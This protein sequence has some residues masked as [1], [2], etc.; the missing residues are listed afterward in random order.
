MMIAVL[1]MTA[2]L[3]GHMVSQSPFDLL[4]AF[5]AMER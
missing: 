4:G 3:F 5:G 1:P 2:L